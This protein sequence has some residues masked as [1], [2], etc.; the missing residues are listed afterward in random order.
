[1]V[2]TITPPIGSLGETIVRRVTVNRDLTPE[3]L[4][5]FCSVNQDAVDCKVLRTLP[6]QGTGIEEV[7]IHFFNVRRYLPFGEIEHEFSI[8]GLEP[9]FYAQIQANI[10]DPAFGDE[11]INGAVWNN[12]GG[13]ASCFRFLRVKDQRLMCSYRR[14]CRTDW[15][16]YSWWLAGRVVG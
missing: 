12:K 14:R 8:R 15:W 3:Q 9:D 2:E 11:H 10:D 1:M 16:Y 7:D 5:E 13:R 4:L 6:R